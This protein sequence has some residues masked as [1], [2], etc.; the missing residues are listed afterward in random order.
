LAVAA[1]LARRPDYRDELEELIRTHFPSRRA[2]CKATGVSEDL[3]SHVLAGRKHLSVPTL[4]QAL[5]RIGYVL[6]IAPAP[7][8]SVSAMHRRRPRHILAYKAGG[9]STR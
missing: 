8:D 2:F 5:E 1:G 3:L 4:I 7:A 9:S 6:H